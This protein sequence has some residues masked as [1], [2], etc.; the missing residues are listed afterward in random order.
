MNEKPKKI[1]EQISRLSFVFVFLIAGVLLIRTFAIPSSLKEKG[2][3]RT[4]A[5]QRELSKEIKYAGAKAC[6]EC[7]E[8]EAARKSHGNHRGL[9]C[10]TCHG[11]ARKH[12]EDPSENKPEVPRTRDFCPR[13]HNYDPSR[14]TGFPQINPVIHNPLKPCVEC[15]DPHAPVPPE[16]PHEC[17][18][19]HAQ[20]FRTK[21]VSP[22]ALLECT[23][24]HTV[25][26]G[27]KTTPRT[28]KPTK[29][30]TREFCGK[31]HA[32]QSEMKKAPKIDMST[33]GEKYLCWQCH[34][35]HMPEVK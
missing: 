19:C 30:E 22:H 35:P 12:A 3:Q 27:H 14:P 6:A 28:V 29:P 24:C 9:S 7:H 5:I 2:F 15:H 11:P 17:S 20:I 1:P 21:E 18:A 33:H 34:Y 23:A 16:T 32:E 8:E 31:C 26:E 4:S 13:C 25:P 10:E